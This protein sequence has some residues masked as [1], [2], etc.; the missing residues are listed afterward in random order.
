MRS[1]DEADELL[2]VFAHAEACGREPDRVGLQP[3]EVKQLIDERAET[4]CLLE[5]C[6]LQLDELVRP[7]RVAAFGERP[8]DSVDGRGGRSQLA[9]ADSV[10]GASTG[11]E[12][13]AEETGQHQRPDSQANDPLAV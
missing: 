8:R 7:E 6:R 3:R 13:V 4:I 12:Q 1:G 11:A 10:R 2:E 9:V 5:Q